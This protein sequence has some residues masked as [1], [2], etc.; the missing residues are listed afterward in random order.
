VNDIGAT[1][2]LDAKPLAACRERRPVRSAH[3]RSNSVQFIATAGEAREVFEETCSRLSPARSKR[4]PSSHARLEHGFSDVAQLRLSTGAHGVLT[5]SPVC[6]PEACARDT[7]CLSLSLLDPDPNPESIELL[8]SLGEVPFTGRE[9]NT[10]LAQLPLT[11]NMPAMMRAG[12]LAHVNLFLTIHHM[13]DF[14]AMMEAIQ[15]LGVRGENVTIIDKEYSYLLTRRVDTHLRARFGARVYRYSQ[16]E[17]AIRRHIEFSRAQGK[18]T[19]VID[20]GGYVFPVLF[21]SFPDCMGDFIGLVEQT[22]SGIWKLDTLPPLPVP[23]F[24][25]AESNLKATIESYGIAD[26][27][28]RNVLALLPHEKFEGQPALVVGFGRIGQEVANVLR[29]RRMHVAV[30]DRE[31]VRVVA[32]HERGFVTSDNLSELLAHHRP[33]LIAGTA[34]A[35]ALTREHFR[36]IARD[37]FAFSV[38]SRDYEFN[39]RDLAAHSRETVRHGRAGTAYQLAHGPSITLLAH[40]FPINFHYA[41]SLPNKYSDIVLA[42]LLLGAC[43]LAEPDHGF[44]DGHNVAKTNSILDRAELLKRY[45]DLYRP[46]FGGPAAARQRRGPEAR[47]ALPRARLGMSGSTRRPRLNLQRGAS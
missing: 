10:V 41:E 45:Y 40:G 24:S 21:R 42:S 23:V 20:D 34:G 27:A 12:A 39:L 47:R 38:T 33:F 7:Y 28:V 8:Q 6:T 37:C 18:R 2:I 46:K 25:V 31:L 1:S 35:N 9:V 3:P 14:L 19:I 15:A 5:V 36:H 22:V 43:T 26:A 29:M 30:Y 44:A 4:R 17:E 11:R 32:A 13:T 16:I